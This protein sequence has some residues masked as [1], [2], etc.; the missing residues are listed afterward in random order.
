MKFLCKFK[1]L[2]MAIP[3]LPT[4]NLYKFG[5]VGFVFLISLLFYTRSAEKNNLLKIK[6]EYDLNYNH[7]I[8][9]KNQYLSSK[10]TSFEEKAELNRKIDESNDMS[11]DIKKRICE[12]DSEASFYNFL[13]SVCILFASVFLLLWYF[14]LQRHQDLIIKKQARNGNDKM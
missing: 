11:K 4:D 7:T 2:I 6:S 10:D 3:N 9:M 8:D 12:F 14:K 1:L 13:L 5:F